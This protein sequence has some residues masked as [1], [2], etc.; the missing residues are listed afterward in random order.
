[1]SF[2]LAVQEKE[3]TEAGKNRASNVR[4]TPHG[5]KAWQ[6]NKQDHLLCIV[7]AVFAGRICHLLFLPWKATGQT[8]GDEDPQLQEC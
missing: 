7:A 8:A 4:K 5:R 3:R 6:G 2:R 1:M